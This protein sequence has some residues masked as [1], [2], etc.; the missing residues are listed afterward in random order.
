MERMTIKDACKMLGMSAPTLRVL[1]QRGCIDIGECIEP[2][3][4]GGKWQYYIY[5]SKVLKMV[6]KGEE[7]ETDN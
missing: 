1:M 5:K 7:N 3:K 2:L 6:G 4:P